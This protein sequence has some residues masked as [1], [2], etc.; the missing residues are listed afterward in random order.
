M[1]II[2]IATKTLLIFESLWALALLPLLAAGIAARR[3]RRRRS[4]ASAAAKPA[5]Q[6]ALAIYLGGNSD[7]ER[8]RALSKANPKETEQSML[9]F[10]ARIGVGGERLGDLALKLG[11]VQRWCSAAESPDSGVRRRGF[12]RMAA[13]ACYEPVRRYIGDI[14]VKALGD[15]DELVRME[16]ARAV[17]ASDNIEE[18]ERVFD[19]VLADSPMIRV[20]VAPELRQHANRLCK[21]AVPKA[22]RSPYPSVL[23]T[24]LRVLASWE[25][26]L[27]IPDLGGLAEHPDV[28]VRI[29]TMQLLPM[30]PMSSENRSA[31]IRGLADGD[32]RVST[33]AI[34]SIG[35][36]KLP[37]GIGQLTS[38]LRRGSEELARAA[39][40][41][42][43]GM[44]PAGLLALE[45]Q[46][47]NPD[48]IASGAAREALELCEM[49][50]VN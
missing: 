7:L 4:A 35:R 41:V 21:S 25:R 43:A 37:E 24:A 14:P 19:L 12:A 6:E 8:L 46:I 27:P 33:A 5:I 44:P 16:A 42:L 22:L 45:G 38:C 20:L 40:M 28:D 29:E 39:A 50:G 30:L 17:A 26:T 10:R 31:L 47:P 13:F 18:I 32:L 23:R 11:L 1:E 3:S 48:P 15:P 9:A 2:D 34:A 36:L 49:A